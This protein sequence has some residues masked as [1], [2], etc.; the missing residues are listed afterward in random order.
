MWSCITPAL[1][2]GNYSLPTMGKHGIQLVTCL[3]DGTCNRWR[4]GLLAKTFC[5]WGAWRRWATPQTV[6]Q[7]RTIGKVYG[8][9]LPPGQMDPAGSYLTA[10]RSSRSWLGF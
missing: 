2:H 1:A 10:Q 3:P 9:A 4:A 5:S 7:P 8:R 6:E